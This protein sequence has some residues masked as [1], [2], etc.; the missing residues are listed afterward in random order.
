M[1]V[2]PV[3]KGH[4]IQ[5]DAV[6]VDG[7]WDATVNIHRVFSDDKPHVE[8]ITCLKLTAELAE[9]RAAIW[10]RR[11]VDLKDGGTSNCQTV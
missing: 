7:R 9:R 8:R 2:E 6:Q 1:F 4:R 11:W 5:V 10:A 3:Y